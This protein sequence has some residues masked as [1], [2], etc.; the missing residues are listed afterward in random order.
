MFIL[1]VATIMLPYYYT[2]DAKANNYTAHQFSMHLVVGVQNSQE[3]LYA[4]H[5]FQRVKK[6]ILSKQIK[7]FIFCCMMPCHGHYQES[8]YLV[9]SILK[10]HRGMCPTHTL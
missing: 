7:F 8:V 2:P 5:E 3:C 6:L 10:S 4:G 9:A 1:T